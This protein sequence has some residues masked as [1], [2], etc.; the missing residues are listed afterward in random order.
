MIDVKKLQELNSK[1]ERA[2]PV[3]TSPAVS[4]RMDDELAR[5]AERWRAIADKVET[6]AVSTPPAGPGQ[7]TA[8]PVVE[9]LTYLDKLKAIANR[10]YPPLTLPEISEEELKATGGDKEKIKK[11]LLERGMGDLFP[12]YKTAPLRLPEPGKVWEG[13]KH[14]VKGLA[15]LPGAVLDIGKGL[16]KGVS[17]ALGGE[18][19]KGKEEIKSSAKAIANLGYEL[20]AFAPK[21]AVDFLHDPAGTIENRPVDIALIVGPVAAGKLIRRAMRG[22]GKIEDVG[23]VADEVRAE[24]RAKNPVEIAK[25]SLEE[26]PKS[27]YSPEEIQSFIKEAIPELESA[28]EKQELLY[29]KERAKR[30]AEAKKALESDTGLEAW[31]KAKAALKGEYEKIK[32]GTLGVFKEKLGPEKIEA[33]YS[34]IKDNQSLS[35]TEKL[36]ALD[37]LDIIFTEGRVPGEA[38]IADLAKVLGREVAE[39]LLR[40]RFALKATTNFLASI[41]NIP[42]TLMASFDLSAPFRQGLYFI[43]HPK[44]FTEA[45]IQNIKTF[46]S[47]KVYREWLMKIK[48]DPAYDAFYAGGGR[49][50]ELEGLLDLKEE[51]F[52]TDIFRKIK[53]AEEAGKLAKGAATAWNV[54]TEGVRASNRAFVAT[55]NKLAFDYYKHFYKMFE[56]RGINLLEHAEANKAIID[57][58]QASVGRAELPDLLKRS[59]AIINATLFSPRLQMSRI[60]FL[61]PATYI[62][63]GVKA[64]PRVAAEALATVFADAAIIEGV[65][66]LFKLN[67]WDV[68]TDPQS[69][70]FMKARKGDVRIDP[71]GG[72]IQYVRAAVRASQSAKQIIEYNLGLT[73]KQPKKTPAQIFWDLARFKLSPIPGAALSL[74]EG[75]TAVGEPIQPGKMLGEMVIPM[76]FRDLYEIWQADPDLLPV[77]VMGL[78]GVGLQTYEEK[79]RKRR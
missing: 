61:N 39:E 6:P 25:P 52:Q 70:D 69:P 58:V 64:G 11:L 79:P 76:S 73:S 2:G 77:G 63:L 47:E 45:F 19:E 50:R 46:G 68:E 1:L 53:P 72:H 51:A 26:L 59:A 5:K 38:A 28:A 12:G 71:W 20:F 8:G 36:H 49:L 67:G 3:G 30:F 56:K 41:G 66:S 4:N 78:F 29:T 14:G 75:Q 62:K 31:R 42:R 60:Y 16:V 10:F 23:E 48:K 37:A 13:V 24:L 18:K 21:L 43:S 55:L 74:M 32:S 9:G 35:F 40:K 27:K 22:K 54:A 44:L 15:E 17:E 7:A 34:F 33:I 57:L 65:L